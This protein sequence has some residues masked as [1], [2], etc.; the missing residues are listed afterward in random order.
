MR[1][2]QLLFQRCAKAVR[3]HS[4]RGLGLLG[5]G[6]CSCTHVVQYVCAICTRLWCRRHEIKVHPACSSILKP[7][8]HTVCDV[9]ALQVDADHS[10]SSNFRA[11]ASLFVPASAPWSRWLALNVCRND[12]TDVHQDDFS[13]G[14]GALYQGGRE[15][16]AQA[17][18]TSEQK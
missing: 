1:C 9:I 8:C 18:R 16:D 15:C 11:C 14:G 12:Q 5:F 6:V 13:S 17:V 7:I 3:R 10:T 2:S 4:C